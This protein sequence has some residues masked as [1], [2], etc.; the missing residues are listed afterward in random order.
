MV[1]EMVGLG[2]IGKER[3]GIEEIEEG[4]QLMRRY[5]TEN[6]RR[7]PGNESKGHNRGIKKAGR[8]ITDV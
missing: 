5:F 8:G 6:Q 3:G 1:G 2:R 7:F 4:G